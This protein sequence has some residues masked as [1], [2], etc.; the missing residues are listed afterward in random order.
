MK[1]ES[2]A[3]ATPHALASDAGAASFAGGGNA[4]DAALAA[5]AV[6]A[7]V[8][9][10]MCSIGGDIIAMIARPDGRVVVVNGSGAAAAA[11]SAE[12]M[13]TL[14]SKMP[15]VGPETVT[16]PGAVGAWETLATLGGRLPLDL[17]LR[18]AIEHAREGAPVAKSLAVALQNS[19]QI[20]VDPG[21]SSVFTFGGELMRR[22]D[23]LRQP[24]LARSL[25]V[26]ADEGG[27]ALYGGTVGRRLCEGLPTYRTYLRTRLR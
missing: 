12:A 23:R 26:I 11:S 4:V 3:I 14:G 25:E 10:H 8:Y 2:C 15:L 18:P 1:S 22:G 21:L 7:V 6:L 9:P 17:V 27:S 16:V 13:R 19:A 5:T 24:A 20:E